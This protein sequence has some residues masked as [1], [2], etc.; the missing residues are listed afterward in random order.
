MNLPGARQCFRAL[1]TLNL[2]S[3]CK[4]YESTTVGEATKEG[5]ITVGSCLYP[6]ANYV[7]P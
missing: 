7:L 1:T 2:G 4:G 3:G 5:H 6:H